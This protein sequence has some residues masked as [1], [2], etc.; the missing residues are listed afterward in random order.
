MDTNFYEGF[1]VL[2]HFVTWLEKRPAMKMKCWCSTSG[3]AELE[4]NPSVTPLAGR[5]SD[6]AVSQSTTIS[7]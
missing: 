4:P 3:V 6:L 2:E 1:L 7:E 5:L